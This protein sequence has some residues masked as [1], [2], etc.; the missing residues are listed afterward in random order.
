[1]SSFDASDEWFAKGFRVRQQK[2]SKTARR[3]GVRSKAG[4]P[5]SS[6]AGVKFSAGAKTKNAKSVVRKAP[7]VMVKI[8]GSS[9]GLASV[10][11]HLDYISRNG[12]VELVNECDETLQGRED[13][14]ALRA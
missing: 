7:E 5:P 3:D 8:T 13:M 2:G 10:K 9:S 12:Q 6:K 1:M 14:R 4:A 11:R